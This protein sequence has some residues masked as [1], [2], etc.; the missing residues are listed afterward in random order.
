[1][2]NLEQASNGAA[3]RFA[4]PIDQITLGNTDESK[5]LVVVVIDVT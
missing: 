4:V 3:G 2:T 1:V 5:E